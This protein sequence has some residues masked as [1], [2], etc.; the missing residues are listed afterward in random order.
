[1]ENVDAKNFRVM[2]GRDKGEPNRKKV[3][4]IKRAVIAGRNVTYVRVYRD[5]TTRE[6]FSPNGAHRQQA[7]DELGL[8]VP[9]IL[10]EVENARERAEWES[11]L[12]SMAFCVKSSAFSMSSFKKYMKPSVASTVALT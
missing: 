5:K 9:V 10:F 3:E 2:Q 1:M 7:F 11:C 8:P 6:L 12:S 4:S